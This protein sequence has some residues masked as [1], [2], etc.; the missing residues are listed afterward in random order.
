GLLLCLI[1]LFL[2]KSQSLF[3]ISVVRTVIFLIKKTTLMQR[4]F[5]IHG[6]EVERIF[7]ITNRAFILNFLILFSFATYAQK[8][9]AFRELTPS[10]GTYKL[11]ALFSSKP[12]SPNESID[13]LKFPFNQAYA[14]KMLSVKPVY[15]QNIS[16]D[17]FKLPDPPANS[18]DQTH[19]EL[20]YLLSL[21]R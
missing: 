15:L 1:N 17:D 19:A 11:F 20:N 10:R 6:K 13:K 5:F 2:F 9:G 21:Q 7:N 8:K 14:D 18:S 12:K 4:K 3:T 16:V